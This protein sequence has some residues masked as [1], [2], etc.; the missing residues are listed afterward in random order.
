MKLIFSTLLLLF[1]INAIGQQRDANIFDNSRYLLQHSQMVVI[2]LSDSRKQLNQP[3]HI[4]PAISSDSLL[5]STTNQNIVNRMYPTKLMFTNCY[6]YCSD[7]RSEALYQC[8]ATG[9]GRPCET[10]AINAYFDC[11]NRCNE[12]PY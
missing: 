6:T 5:K 10:A 2:E 11:L 3:L 4:V 9:G 7:L 8:W 12:Q 1:A